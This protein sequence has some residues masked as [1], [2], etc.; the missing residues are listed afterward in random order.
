VETGTQEMPV[1]EPG[2]VIISGGQIMK[3][4]LNN[5]EA[6]AKTIRVIDGA[7]WL[8]TGD[9]AVQDADGYVTICDRAKDMLIVGGYKVFS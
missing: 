7:R 6:T 4:Y 2:E 3:G 8:H 9:I 1:G 5:P